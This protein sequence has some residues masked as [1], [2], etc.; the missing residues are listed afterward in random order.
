MKSTNQVV[1]PLIFFLLIGLICLLR[2][3][4]V[5]PFAI[6]VVPGSMSPIV[7]RAL[8]HS[9]LM[10]GTPTR[11][12]R[13]IREAE[14]RVQR[15]PNDGEG[16][17]AL[18]NA[19]MQKSRETNDP[20][21]YVRAETAVQ[22]A[23]SLQPDSPSALRTLAWVQ[24]GKHE[25][26]EARTTAERLLVQSPLDPLAYGL[27]GDAALELGDYERAAITSGLTLEDHKYHFRDMI[28]KKQYVEYLVSTPKNC[29]C[30]YLAE[31]LE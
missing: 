10:V 27:L 13:A 20:D 29:T 9:S 11:A 15:L 26:R 22:R 7:S 30:T 18:A 25:F 8:T 21:Y 31:H 12:D 3:A 4:N 14:A 24:T 23:L 1:R 17:V 6:A 19:Y 5:A 28:T 2:I 16:Y